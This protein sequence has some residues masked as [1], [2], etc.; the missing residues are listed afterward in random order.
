MNKTTAIQHPLCRDICF[1][2]K[3]YVYMLLLQLKWIKPDEFNITCQNKT[4]SN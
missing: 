2:F 4:N 3:T 1:H